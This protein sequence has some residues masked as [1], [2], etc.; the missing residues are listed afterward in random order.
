LPPALGDRIQ[1]QQVIMNL[2]VNGS[3]A[4]VPVL[5][6]PR[7]LRIG[8]KPDSGGDTIIVAV[9]DLGTGIDPATA[10]RIFDPLFTT[11]RDGMGMG[12]S[13]CRSI[14][15]A[16]GGRLW[17]TPGNSHGAVFQFTLPTQTQDTQASVS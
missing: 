7:I 4:M 17:V 16:H 3:D 12:L 5:D 14:I 6:R 15:Q 9:E 2:I 13:I 11:K 1:L 10:D 8:S